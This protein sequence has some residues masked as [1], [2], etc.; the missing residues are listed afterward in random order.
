MLD[1]LLDEVICE[2]IDLQNLDPK[3]I[4]D[5]LLEKLTKIESG[6]FQLN[7]ELLKMKVEL[8]NKDT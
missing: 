2:L 1:D 8:E 7:V 3:L 5:E 6:I 4:S